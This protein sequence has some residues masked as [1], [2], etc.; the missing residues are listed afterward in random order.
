MPLHCR[1]IELKDKFEEAVREELGLPYIQT[2][3]HKTPH[4]PLIWMERHCSHLHDRFYHFDKM[5]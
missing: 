1:F 3:K 4:M 2:E 5:I